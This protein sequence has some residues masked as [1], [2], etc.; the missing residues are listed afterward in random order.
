LWGADKNNP[1]YQE[2][3]NSLIWLDS[4]FESYFDDLE[5]INLNTDDVIEG[6]ETE[7]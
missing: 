1:K 2:F 4:S 6:I 3:K 7:S 5:N